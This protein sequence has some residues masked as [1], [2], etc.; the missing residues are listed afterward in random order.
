PNTA[1]MI[2]APNAMSS[3]MRMD[4]IR[5]EST[6]RPSSSVPSQCCTFP[7]TAR[8]FFRSKAV[9]LYGLIQSAVAAIRIIAAI[10][11]NPMMTISGMRLWFFFGCVETAAVLAIISVIGSASR[12]ALRL[13]QTRIEITIEKIDHEIGD[14][15]RRGHERQD[16]VHDREVAIRYRH[17][18]RS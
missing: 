15:H 5:R 18:R 6:S 17:D 3:E 4:S 14:H 9:M 7:G 16:A 12:L 13:T 10:Q 1:E 11:T 8:R 2:V